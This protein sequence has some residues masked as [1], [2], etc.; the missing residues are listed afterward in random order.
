MCLGAKVFDIKTGKELWEWPEKKADSALGPY[1]FS[2]PEGLEIRLAA[3]GELVWPRA[4]GTDPPLACRSFTN[5]M[6]KEPLEMIQSGKIEKTGGLLKKT[7]IAMLVLGGI[8]GI[9]AFLTS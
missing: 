2:A 8:A 9:V 7:V 4:P 6:L 5:E 3:N 1:L